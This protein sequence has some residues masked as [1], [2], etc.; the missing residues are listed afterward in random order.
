MA[1]LFQNIFDKIEM[2]KSE[3]VKPNAPITPTGMLRGR[4]MIE[5]MKRSADAIRLLKQE[6]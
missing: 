4:K 2:S 1:G 6:K 5:E 3:V